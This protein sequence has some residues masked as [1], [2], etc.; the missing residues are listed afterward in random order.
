LGEVAGGLDD[1]GAH[2][3]DDSR[4]VLGVGLPRVKL[5]VVT[6]L[7]RLGVPWATVVHPQAT[8]GPNITIG[9][10]SYIA[11][12]TIL[13]V[14]A[15]IGRFVTVN[16][17]C[18]VAHDDVVEDFVTLHPDVHLSGN[19]TIGVGCELGTG[20]IVIPGRQVGDWAVLGA[21]CVAVRS[22]PGGATYVGLPAQAVTRHARFPV[23]GER[24][25]R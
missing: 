4:L 3:I 24:G 18:Q 5:D 9:E 13:T 6:R 17:H 25:S 2:V 8:I 23:E 16:L 19:V 12:G 11:A 20:S 21:G 15:G 10:G 14:N 22:L 7:E 1:V